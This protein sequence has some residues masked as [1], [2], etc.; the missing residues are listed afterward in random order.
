MHATL[1][2]LLLTLPA[3]AAPL[4]VHVTVALCD[5]ASQGI[6]PVPVAIGDG[7]DPRTNL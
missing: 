5:N 2:A 4:R 1:L 7:N 3:A 6:V